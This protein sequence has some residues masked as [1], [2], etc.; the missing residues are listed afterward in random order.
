MR[1]PFIMLVIFFTLKLRFV[2]V[3]KWTFFLIFL[4]PR[5]QIQGCEQYASG[6]VRNMD[7]IGP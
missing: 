4:T 1:G 2:V 6:I 7:R 3:F 5:L